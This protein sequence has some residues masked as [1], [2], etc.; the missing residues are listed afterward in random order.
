MTVK[1]LSSLR[2]RILLVGVAL[3][4]GLSGLLIANT[5]RILSAVAVENIRTTLRQT[6]E[7]LNLAITPY[8]TAD[9]IKTLGDYFQE[10]V[11]GEETGIVYLALLDEN[12]ELLLKTDAVP[13]PLPP[14][15]ADLGRQFREGIVH[16]SQPILLGGAEVGAL[17]YGLS[18]TLL[19]DAIPRIVRENMILVGA[20]LALVVVLVLIAGIRLNTRITRLIRASRALTEGDYSTR[21]PEHGK[22]ELSLLGRDFNAMAQA[23][24]ERILALETSRREIRE[25]N[26]TLEQRVRER[27]HELA[28]RNAEL[29]EVIRN[30]RHTREVLARSEKLASLG[31]IVAAVAHELSTP[32][33]NALTVATAFVEKTKTFQKE[34]EQGLRRSSLEAYKN[35]SL[36]AAELVERNLVRAA[37]LII[38]FKHVAVDQTSSQRRTFDL[39]QTL[40][41]IVA[42][43]KP[44]FRNVPYTLETDLASGL[45]MD[46]YPGPIG[47]VITNFVNNTLVHGFEGRARGVMR[48]ACRGLDGDRVE[49]VYADDGVGI[50]PEYLQRIYDPF[51]TTRLGTGGSGLGLHIVHNIVTG[52]LGGSIEVDSR[53]GEG[54][55]FTV[56]LPR[57]AP[58]TINQNPL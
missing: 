39:E 5:F 58:V 55:A 40:A 7:T 24:N 2:F 13:L 43:L 18:S 51:F 4:L 52:L 21:A 17:R 10:L 19:K 6:S 29:D 1:L 3:M 15:D 20:G 41:E 42:T 31:S 32:I 44:S 30:L 14:L 25:L 12:G 8:T 16:A 36:A 46:S 35:D 54:T 9:G 49:I 47:Q 22:D 37:D 38:S 53:A 26:Q 27:T 28:D 56:T 33:G 48:L 11:S 57:I 45:S 23:V 50:P 34:V